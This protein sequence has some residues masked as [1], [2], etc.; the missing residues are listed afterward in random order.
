MAEKNINFKTRVTGTGAAKGKIKSVEQTAVKSAGTMGAA[1]KKMAGV[2]GI[3]FGGTMLLGAASDLV[4]V[5]HKVIGVE[6]AFKRLDDPNLLSNLRDATKGTIDDLKLMQSAVFADKM[7][8]PM[9]VLAKGMEF[10]GLTAIETGQDINYMM[11]SFVTGTARQSIMILDNLGISSKE[12]SEEIKIT[13]DFMIALGNIMDRQLTRMRGGMDETILR[14]QQ[15]NTSL[16]NQKQIVSVGLA[17]GWDFFLGGLLDPLSRAINSI[18]AFDEW[19]NN[20]NEDL[21]ELLGLNSEDIPKPPENTLVKWRELNFALQKT[22]ELY[23]ALGLNKTVTPK[24]TPWLKQQQDRLEEIKKLI[25]AGNLSQEAYLA[26]L[27]DQ[28]KIMEGLTLPTQKKITKE[29]E[30]QRELLKGVVGGAGI[31]LTGGRAGETGIGA[32]GAVSFSGGRGKDDNPI[33]RATEVGLSEGFKRSEMMMRNAGM[34]WAD[35]LH[36]S[37]N[38]FWDETFGYANSLLEQLLKVTVS[39]LLGDLLRL[40]LTAGLAFLTMGGGAGAGAAAPVPLAPMI[41]LK[42]GE[43]EVGSFVNT[44]NAYNRMRRL[45]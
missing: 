26:L 13:G 1:F 30:K 20:L 2:M 18:R 11:E 45:N 22:N 4:K 3:A 24:V 37:F 25:D 7:R 15:L 29:L 34:R 31:G 33:T 27:V 38:Q 42:I 12:L 36:T 19:V 9:D 6:A 14:T 8:I 28:A 32:G 44:G 10:A 5:G 40:G 39:S 23:G 16:E 41:I 35:T 21:E 17:R 43:E